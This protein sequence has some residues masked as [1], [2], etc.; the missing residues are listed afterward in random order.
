MLD[1]GTGAG[2]PG[3]VL[4]IALADTTVILAEPLKSV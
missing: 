3:L 4:A 2:F 1:V